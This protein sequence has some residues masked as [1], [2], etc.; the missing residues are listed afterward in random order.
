MGRAPI[1]GLSDP[2]GGPAEI[3]LPDPSL[4]VLIGPAGSGKSTFARRWF[5][6]DEILSSDAFRGRLG[7]GEADQRASG[8][9]FQALHGALD[10]RLLSGRLTVVDATSIRAESRRPLLRAAA[11]AR[12][13]AVA[14]VLDMSI[15][16]CLAGDLARLDRHVGR[17]VIER[18]W[19]TLRP[20]IESV[21]SGTSN[22]TTR[23][24][25]L[26]LA[27]GF[28]QAI[29]LAGRPAVDSVGVRRRVGSSR[30]I[31]A[32]PDTGSQSR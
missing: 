3:V 11:G 27:E 6:A 13:P 16:E 25:P 17:A 10:E 21:D 2:V 19:A 20:L 32:R 29:R 24:V 31:G 22:A 26:L 23:A 8:R 9:A 18:Q 1:A 30:T 5:A 7:R 12:L 28:D 14:I 15:D 4:V